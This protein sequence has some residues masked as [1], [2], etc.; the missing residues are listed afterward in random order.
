MNKL[1]S[2]PRNQ[3]NKFHLQNHLITP[4]QNLQNDP[5]VLAPKYHTDEDPELPKS[6]SPEIPNTRPQPHS[7]GSF[8][9]LYI[10]TDTELSARF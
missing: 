5:G 6:H 1:S 7:H 3:R 2:T 9:R 8:E 4:G 10:V